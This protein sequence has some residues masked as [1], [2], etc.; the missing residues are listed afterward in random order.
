MNGTNRRSSM[1][2][3]KRIRF[4]KRRYEE[5]A[6]NASPKG[7][8]RN[9]QASPSKKSHRL[10]RSSLP[11]TAE[12][13]AAHDNRKKETLRPRSLIQNTKSGILKKRHKHQADNVKQ[14]YLIWENTATKEGQNFEEFSIP[15]EWIKDN[16]PKVK[17]MKRDEPSSSSSSSSSST[18]IEEQA[19]KHLLSALKRAKTL[20]PEAFAKYYPTLIDF[21]KEDES[22]E[23]KNGMMTRKKQSKAAKSRTLATASENSAPDSGEDGVPKRA[24]K[25]PK[26]FQDYDIGDEAQK[27]KLASHFPDV[28]KEKRDNVVKDEPRSAQKISRINGSS[29]GTSGLRKRSGASTD[30]SGKVDMKQGALN[31]SMPAKKRGRSDMNANKSSM[32]GEGKR[33]SGDE[34]VVDSL[35][36][37]NNIEDSA[38]ETSSDESSNVRTSKRQ[39]AQSGFYK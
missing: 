26:A 8:S 27:K 3:S 37:Q 28:K 19:M 10:Q 29:A 38:A 18:S 12:L 13:K 32:I 11:G 20:Y 35:I 30:A 15:K 17:K 9:G 21:F 25:M 23:K 6:P 14:A 7:R 22:T 16:K 31:E 1:S 33:K 5:Y 4:K 39:R 34:A 2:S 36:I 24:R